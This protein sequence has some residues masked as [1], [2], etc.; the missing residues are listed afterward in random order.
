MRT[1]LAVLA[2]LFLGTALAPAAEKPPAFVRK[3]T[4][5]AAGDKVKI[6]FELDRAVDVAV[7]VEDAEGRIVR[8]LAAGVLGE[9]APEPLAAGALA[10]AITWDRTDDAGKPAGAGPFRVRVAAGLSA[11]YAGTAFGSEPKPDDLTNVIGLA[12]GPDG[13]VYAMSQRW[14]RAHWTHTAVHVFLR[15]GQYEKTIKPFAPSIP[16]ERIEGLTGLKTD[17]GRPMPVI[18]RILA[19][20]YYPKE[21]MAQHMAVS[22]DG[23]LHFLVSRAAYRKGSPKFLASM[24]LDG[25]MAYE[26]YAGPQLPSETSAGDPYLVASSGGESDEESDGEAIFATGVERGSGSSGES[27]A[28]RPNTPVV[29]RINL[30]ERDKAEPFFGDPKTVG[31]DEA[32]LKDPR[33][34]ALDSKGHLLIA[35]R[36]N[37]RVVMVDEKDGKF[38]RAFDVPSPTW[39]G[40]HKSGAVYV[41]SGSDVIKFVLEES[42]GAVEQARVKLPPVDPKYKDKARRSFALDA[43][44]ENPVLWVGLSRGGTA[45]LRAEE[46]DGRFS[47]LEPAGYRPARTYWNLCVGLDRKTVGCKAGHTTLRLLD[48]DTGETRDLRLTG[49]SGQTYRIGP[50]GQIYGMD[51][52]KWGPRRWDKDGKPLPYPATLNHPEPGGKG[53]LPSVPTGTTSWERDFDVDRAGNVYVKHRGKKYH[54]RMRVDKYDPDGN[55]LGT[56]L[57]VVSD[58]SLGPRLDPAGNVYIAESVRPAGKQIPDYFE[59]KLPEAPIDKRANVLQQYRW[60]YGSVIKFAPAGGAVWFPIIDKEKDVYGFDGETGLPESMKK[61]KVDT[62][63]G[64][65]VA[66]APGELQGA[67]WYRYGCSYLLDMHPAH[68]RRCHCT[69]TEFEVDDFG[70]VFYTDQGRFR[71][72]VLDTAG[73]EITA[74]GAYGNQDYCGPD[75]YVMDPEGKFLR[76]R[77]PDDP[78]DLKSPFAE[79]ALAFNWFVGL[80]VSDRYVY[81]A[82]GS[83][84]RVVRASLDYAVQS[85]ADVQ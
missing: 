47:D 51:H 54:G 42:E 75:S 30:P 8:H 69:S 35:D 71:V 66:T 39:I 3:P 79:P 15:T 37:N 19:M 33:G 40:V 49:S 78:E 43:A 13:R 36:G 12:V 24:G 31:D 62:S 20:S 64:D 45:L 52:W 1:S 11:A 46:K 72:V 28:S 82:D 80:G 68:N 84:R 34:L 63:Q 81:V 70:R 5:V 65:R 53:R 7:F 9:K 76:P 17:D 38:V 85:S 21:D 14:K 74:F 29:Y 2:C 6:E 55:F 4:A 56:V 16:P 10:Q 83:N 25:G 61:V 60:M 22:P 27:S 32:H 58:G 57:W 23:K 50:E 77:K 59:D 48:E 67:L 44:A 41:A 73:N 26:A 18:Y